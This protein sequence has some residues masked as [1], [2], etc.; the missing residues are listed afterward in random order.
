MLKVDLEHQKPAAQNGE[1]IYKIS[2]E[3]GRTAS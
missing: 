2:K 3:P 1:S